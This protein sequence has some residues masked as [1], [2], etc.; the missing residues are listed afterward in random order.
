MPDQSATPVQSNLKEVRSI[1]PFDSVGVNVVFRDGSM[2]T[3]SHIELNY[4][5][6]IMLY[7][8]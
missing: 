2:I 5:G 3:A 4:D 1:H 7:I 8:R 6:L